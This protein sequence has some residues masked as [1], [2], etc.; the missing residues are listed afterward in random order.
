ML[1]PDK[2]DNAAQQAYEVLSLALTRCEREE[3]QRLRRLIEA[4]TW[5]WAMETSLE[6]VPM[7]LSD[8]H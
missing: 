3:R 5:A 1:K 4:M 7:V 8:E 2:I 6:I